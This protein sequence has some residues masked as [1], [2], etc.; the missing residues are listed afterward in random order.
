MAVLAGR[1]QFGP[2]R[3]RIILRTFRDGLA[4]QAGHD[5]GL[6]RL[7]PVGWMNASRASHAADYS[8][9]AEVIERAILAPGKK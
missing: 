5:L 9:M 2:D 7:D 8:L 3:G 4:A 6:T 1:H